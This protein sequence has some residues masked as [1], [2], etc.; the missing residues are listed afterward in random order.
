MTL[1][2]ISILNL[3]D[4][5]KY[6][7]GI[8][9]DNKNTKKHKVS[10][11]FDETLEIVVNKSHVETFICLESLLSVRRSALI[12]SNNNYHIL[13]MVDPKLSTFIKSKTFVL[14]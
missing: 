10:I 9:R 7:T 14:I 5:K 3:I 6:Y 11:H 2:M 8:N 4:L 12:N 1:F 13:N